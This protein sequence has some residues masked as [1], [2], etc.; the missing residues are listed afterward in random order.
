MIVKKLEVKFISNEI[1]RKG[2]QVLIET[3]IKT[4]LEVP[5]TCFNIKLLYKRRKTIFMNRCID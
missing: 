5:E 4:V 1:L 3:K 2:L